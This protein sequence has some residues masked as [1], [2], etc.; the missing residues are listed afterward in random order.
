MGRRGSVLPVGGRAVH[1]QAS[2]REGQI[3]P[4]VPHQAE[5][6]PRT[7]ATLGGRRRPLSGGGRRLLLRRRRG[8]QAGFEWP[9]GGIRA[10]LEGLALIVAQRG[11]DRRSVG[12]CLGC[13]MEE[14]RGSGGVEESDTHL[15]RRAP[16]DVVGSGGRGGTILSQEGAQGTRGYYRSRKVAP[17]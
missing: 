15:P 13:R 6:S 3:R 17:P 14:R 2:L 8:F 1:A 12:G 16:G 7:R 10:G 4:P 9:W 5:D 11:D